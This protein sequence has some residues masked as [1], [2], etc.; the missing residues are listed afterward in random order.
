M[1]NSI[2]NNPLERSSNFYSNCFWDNA[3][4]EEELIKINEYCSQLELQTGTTVG[5]LEPEKLEKIRKSNVNFIKRTDDNGWIFDR[6]N[7]IIYLVNERFYNFSL[8]GYSSIQYTTYTEEDKG[9]YNWH[10][11]MHHDRSNDSIH[12]DP[13]HRKLSMTFLLNDDFE[14]GDF[15]I[16][17][18]NPETPR[19]IDT[20]KGRAIFFPSFFIHRVTPVTKGTRKS[21]VIWVTGN[22]FY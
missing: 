22:K 18:G 10:M 15:E 12:S 16:C 8:N 20:H 21:L 13:Q 2:Y 5:T 14:G 4:T 11:D 17:V 19:K 6:F 9:F 7:Q 3:F 1:Y